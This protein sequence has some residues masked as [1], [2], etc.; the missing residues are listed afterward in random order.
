MLKISALTACVSALAL[1]S[2]PATA[3]DMPAIGAWN[4]GALKV[5]EGSPLATSALALIKAQAAK[6]G[7]E[8]LRKATEDAAFNSETCI[9]HRANLDDAKKAGHHR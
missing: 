5:A 1:L 4:A 6:I 2:T 3:A 8:S 7:N 9:M